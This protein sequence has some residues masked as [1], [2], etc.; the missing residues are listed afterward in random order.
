M[1]PTVESL[2]NALA[3]HSL[4]PGD[5]VQKLYQRWKA[6]QP[7]GDV[8]AFTRWLVA[9][10]HLTEFQA[11]VLGRG[12]AD[13]LHIGAY[14]ILDRIGKGRMAGVYKGVHRLGQTVAIKVLPPSRAKDPT[15]LARFQREARMA[16]KLKHPNIVRTFQVG[17]QGDLYYLI[18]EYLEGET[19]EDVLKRRSTLPPAEAV[20]LI[21]QALEG[22]EHVHEQGLIHRDLKPA[23]LMLVPARAAG[24]P[25][26]TLW[27]T[28]KILDIGVGRALFDE[29]A[30]EG[31]FELTN[32]G[33]I[34]GTPE[35]L[36]PEQA[37]DARVVDIRS[38][39]YSLGC[40]L[41]HAL[42]GR[43]PFVDASRVRLLV[44]HATEA[45]RPVREFS[46]SMPDGLQQILDWMLAKDPSQRYPTPARAAQALQVYLSATDSRAAQPDA[47]MNA[48]LQWLES[49]GEEAGAVPVV[50]AVRIPDPAPA[51][52]VRLVPVSPP[53]ASPPVAAPRPPAPPRAPAPRARPE[54]AR[55]VA[56]PAARVPP[57][58]PPP[59]PKRKAPVEADV[60]LVETEMI[61]PSGG[62]SH[63]DMMLL[64]IGG[65]V[66]A[67]IALLVTLLVLLL[68]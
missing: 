18:M 39:I 30:S 14:T 34:L 42:A 4:L 64:G 60:E 40:V 29:D 27:A 15:T 24:Q 6:E 48:Y 35:Y 46:P 59:R 11:G 2:C 45:P 62:L 47:R 37:R 26:N 19:L 57:P 22:L 31:N 16:M 8:S 12:H 21:H 17:Q 43:P 61:E 20:R 13:S 33:D 23:N 3:R 51:P 44:R 65:G 53:A 32:E 9:N 25:D 41:Y 50:E 10:H 66:I 68:N 7:G 67:L 56:R 52:P 55:P 54:P 1:E 49:E 28:M 63:R 58:A 36:S 5:E 38:D